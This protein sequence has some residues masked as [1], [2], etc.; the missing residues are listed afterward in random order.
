MYSLVIFCIHDFELQSVCQ[1]LVVL[2]IFFLK[3]IHALE[4]M[5]SF[6]MDIISFLQSFIKVEQWRCILKQEQF[7]P[8]VSDFISA[9]STIEVTFLADIHLGIINAH[10]RPRIL[11]EFLWHM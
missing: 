4:M 2:K 10:N 5:D 8:Y 9:T 1:I 3:V 11:L 7:K 6:K